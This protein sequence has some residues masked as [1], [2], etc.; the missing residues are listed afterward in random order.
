M[1]PVGLRV[2][3]TDTASTHRRCGTL[4]AL[5]LV[6][7]TPPAAQA[8]TPAV[9]SV[10][11]VPALA[12]SDVPVAVELDPGDQSVFKIQ[13]DIQIGTLTPVDL[14]SPTTPDCTPN[15][16]LGLTTASFACISQTGCTRIR[17]V[18]QR[19][20]GP[21]LPAAMLY[22]CNYAVDPSAA[23]G[24]YPLMV[25]ALSVQ[26]GVGVQ[27]PSSSQNGAIDVVTELPPTPTVT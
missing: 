4:L 8:A 2:R 12:G 17:A 22:S 1:R 14:V 13:N 10:D 25:L 9:V 26:N 23:V 27:V 20:D 6:F 18:L 7:A 21:P 11:T 16:T 15:P 24:S 19:L 3:G 5:L